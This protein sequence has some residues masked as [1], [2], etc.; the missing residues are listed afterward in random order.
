VSRALTRK[1]DPSLSGSFRR[2]LADPVHGPLP[3]LMLVLTVLTGVVD[4]VS[5][6]S[7][8]RASSS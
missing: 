2:L 1:S 3:A 5:I 8:G 6:L 4:A 7:L